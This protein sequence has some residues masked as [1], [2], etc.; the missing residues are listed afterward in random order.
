MNNQRVV[1]SSS[2]FNQVVPYLYIIP[3]LSL[4]VLF[5]WWPFFQ[6]IKRSLYHT[7]NIGQN[8]QFIGLD[9]Y[10]SLVNDA[11]FWNSIFVTFKFVALVVLIGII[12]GFSMALLVQKRFPGVKFFS[13]SYA[14]PMAI[15]SSGMAM[16]FKVMLNPNVGILNKLLNSHVKW[17]LEPNIALICVGFLTGWLNCGSNFLFFSAGLSAVDEQLYESASIDGAN[18]FQKFFYI[19][20]PSLRPILFFVVVTNIISAFSSFNQINLLTG[21][22]PRESTNVIVYDIY[23]NAFENFKYGYASAESVIL[24]II[25]LLFT[26][27]LF[28]FRHSRKE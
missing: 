3:S 27:I 11:K 14:I 18:G 22:G 17:L 1:K 20:L 12:L 15:A 2:I 9:N 5:I 7:N 21:G 25:V 23:K 8:S 13:T 6:T 16:I 24:F 19:T 26:I 10:I 4:L 28:N